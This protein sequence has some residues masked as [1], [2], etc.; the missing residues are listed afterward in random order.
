MLL[1][2]SMLLS[3]DALKTAE[4]QHYK[5]LISLENRTDSNMVA[6][7]VPIK[8]SSGM[9]VGENIF[10]QVILKSKS[11]HPVGLYLGKEVDLRNLAV[12]AVAWEMD[13][14]F[15]VDALRKEPY[16]VDIFYRPEFEIGPEKYGV[17]AH[18]IIE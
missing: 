13:S 11:E 2:S 3:C 5:I 6:V 18:F 14:G 16:K 17:F 12:Y 7:I 1:L 4:K 8:M 9:V 15:G 10:E